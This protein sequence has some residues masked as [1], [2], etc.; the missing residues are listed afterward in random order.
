IPDVK[1][2]SGFTLG[3]TYGG[4]NLGAAAMTALEG[5][6]ALAGFLKSSGELANMIGGFERRQEE[7]DFQAD[8]AKLELKQIDKQL[9]A[10]EIRLAIAEK[11]LVNQDQ[12]IENANETD[13]YMRDKFTNKE[14]YDWM[15]GQIS[16]VYFTS[17]Q[18]A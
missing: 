2:G 9:I 3:T 13:A 12:Q 4:K 17:Y 5:G 11:E 6:Q 18:L 14:L 10:A 1:I 8:Q 16:S 15:I 7:W